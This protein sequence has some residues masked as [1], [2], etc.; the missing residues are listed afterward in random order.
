MDGFTAGQLVQVAD[1][2]SLA[3][4]R[5]AMVMGGGQP[6][7]AKVRLVD[8][9][10]MVEPTDDPHIGV[11]VIETFNNDQ[12]EAVEGIPIAPFYAIVAID[13]RNGEQEY[14][15]QVLAR[16][17]SE[18]FESIAQTIAR[19]GYDKDDEAT[20]YEVMEA[21]WTDFGATVSVADWEL[22]TLA[23]YI[24]LRDILADSTPT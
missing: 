9:P 18:N 14:R 3:Y 19:T 22:I 23:R 10:K 2:R 7:Q 15:Q 13:E 11:M 16:G 12:L 6:T 1:T 24:A 4:G 20:W 5:I 17:D 21:Y 8:L